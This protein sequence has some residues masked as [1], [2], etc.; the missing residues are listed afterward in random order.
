MRR[1]GGSRSD[2]RVNRQSSGDG[3]CGRRAGISRRLGRAVRR[4]HYGPTW[5]GDLR[6][7]LV[8]LRGTTSITRRLR[9]CALFRSGCGRS[10]KGLLQRRFG[11]VAHRAI[12]Q[13]MQDGGELR[14]SVRAG[15]M[16]EAGLGATSCQ[17]AR[18]RTFISRCRGSGWP[19]R[20]GLRQFVA[21][22][23]GKTMHRLLE[24]IEPNSEADTSGVL[25]LIL[26]AN[27]YRW[28][29]L[30]EAG[31]TFTDSGPGTCH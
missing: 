8:R 22:T 15:A 6:T 3:V 21:G 23:G 17:R 1:V 4:L 24:V 14:C 10:H 5:G 25:K 2:C 13:R 27:S 19:C 11:L 30:P 31:K 18:W 12:E 9:I 7:A 29:F 28:S 20:R 26:H 16:A